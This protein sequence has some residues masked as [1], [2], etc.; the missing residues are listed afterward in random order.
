M[1]LETGPVPFYN[2]NTCERVV[3]DSFGKLGVEGDL[4]NTRNKKERIIGK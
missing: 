1:A 2:L 4:K 3:K